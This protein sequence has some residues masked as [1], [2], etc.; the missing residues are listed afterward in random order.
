M[1]GGPPE[2]HMTGNV[3]TGVGTNYGS[4]AARITEL[5]WPEMGL[6]EIST[7]EKGLPAPCRFTWRGSRA[8]AA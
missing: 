7:G 4:R 3:M 1:T 6:G 2:A 8:E 5:A